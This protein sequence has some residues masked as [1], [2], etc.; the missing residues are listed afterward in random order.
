MQETA[1]IVRYS[2]LKHLEALIHELV[3]VVVEL[4]QDHFEIL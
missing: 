3:K 1:P 4:L 2:H